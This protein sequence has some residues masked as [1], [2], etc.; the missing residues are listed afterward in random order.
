MKWDE[1]GKK[2]KIHSAQRKN[3]SNP[4][5]PKYSLIEKEKDKAKVNNL[6]INLI[7][8]LEKWPC[9]FNLIVNVKKPCKLG[10]GS[11][12]ILLLLH[13]WVFMKYG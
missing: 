12:I 13:G 3:M 5:N 1:N 2:R 10:A 4:V 6:R 8:V 9:C 11:S 7:T